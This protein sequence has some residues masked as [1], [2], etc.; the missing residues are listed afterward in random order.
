MNAD[1]PHLVVYLRPS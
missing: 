1:P